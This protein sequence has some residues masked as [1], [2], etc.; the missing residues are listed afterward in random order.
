[1]RIIEN[2]ILPP[3]GYKAMTVLNVV[4]VRRGC[5]MRD[6]DFRHEAVHWEQEKEL[7]IVGFYVLYVLLFSLMFLYCLLSTHREPC[8]SGR[9]GLWHSA[10]RMTAFEREAYRHEGDAGYIGRRRPFAWLWML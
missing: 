4:F 5:V 7:L 10:Y 1:M 6:A 3:R 9:W 8:A 2:N